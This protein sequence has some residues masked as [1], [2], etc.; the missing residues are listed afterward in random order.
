M[1]SKSK[2][3]L[4]EQLDQLPEKQLLSTFY[5]VL[6]KGDIELATDMLRG[7]STAK[8]N[9]VIVSIESYNLK[10]YAEAE[11]LLWQSVELL[12]KHMFFY[13]RSAIGK[14]VWNK[15]KDEDTMK[16]LK[17]IQKHWLA[18]LEQVKA[19]EIPSFEHSHAQNVIEA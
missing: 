7:L 6:G 17:A 3:K 4:L 12:T 16:E 1:L 10:S 5:E 19:P 11:Y 13:I 18:A 14:D 15:E 8:R 9:F 2:N